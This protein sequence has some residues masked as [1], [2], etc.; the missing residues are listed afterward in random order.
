M[1]SSTT[2]PQLAEQSRQSEPSKQWLHVVSHLD[3]KYGGLSSVVPQLNSA[4]ASLGQYSVQLTGFCQPGEH[5]VPKQTACVKVEHL[6]LS[7]REWMTN[8]GL[9]VCLYRRPRAWPLAAKQ[10]SD[11]PAGA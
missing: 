7:R 3:P 1:A 4:I 9:Q 6:P 5:F 10:R 8:S 11:G 2:I